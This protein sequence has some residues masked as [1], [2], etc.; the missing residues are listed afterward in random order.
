MFFRCCLV[1]LTRLADRDRVIP[2]CLRLQHDDVGASGFLVCKCGDGAPQVASIET[3][4]ISHQ[5]THVVYNMYNYNTRSASAYSGLLFRFSPL[6]EL[7]M[8]QWK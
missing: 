3:T 7:V 8:L 6:V 2:K 1:R 4:L 5:I